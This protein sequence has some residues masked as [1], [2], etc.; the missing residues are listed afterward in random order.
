MAS[1]QVERVSADLLAVDNMIAS[2]AADEQTCIGVGGSKALARS[3][4]TWRQ[5]LN[6]AAAHATAVSRTSTFTA[7]QRS[8][9]ARVARAVHEVASYP[10]DKGFCRR[11]HERYT[12]IEIDLAAANR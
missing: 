10:E 11:W 8:R 4:K 12:D 5:L 6:V 3:V 2:V 7:N 1:Q 9:M